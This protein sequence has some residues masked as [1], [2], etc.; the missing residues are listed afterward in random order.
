MQR[1]NIFHYHLFMQHILTAILF[2]K[3]Q[4]DVAEKEEK[5]EN[6]AAV[7]NI[8]MGRYSLI[9]VRFGRID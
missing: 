6:P 1:S 2:Y 4:G 9:T 5:K 3:L 8:L 7:E